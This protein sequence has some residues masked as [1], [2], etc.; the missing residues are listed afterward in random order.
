MDYKEQVDKHMQMKKDT[1][2][3]TLSNCILKKI[4]PW[5]VTITEIELDLRKDYQWL[6]KNTDL[7]KLFSCIR[8]KSPSSNLSNH[9]LNGFF[10]QLLRYHFRNL[11]MRERKRGRGKEDAAGSAGAILGF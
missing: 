7:V 6:T 10:I 3:F 5:K 8:D 9:F 2:I 4:I 1:A 11:C